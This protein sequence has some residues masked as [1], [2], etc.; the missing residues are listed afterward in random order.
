MRMPPSSRNTS[1]FR[2]SFSTMCLT[3]AAYSSGR[4]NRFGNCTCLERLANLVARLRHHRRVHDP[5]RDRAA[6]DPEARELA[7]DGEHHPE[8]AALR[9]RVGD[10][11]DLPFEARDGGGVDDHAS[12][13]GLRRLG[14]GD[15]LGGKPDHVERADEVHVH[16]STEAVEVVRPV[17]AEH[18]LGPADPGAADCAVETAERVDGGRHGAPDAVLVADVGLDEPARALALTQV[19][20]DDVSAGAGELLGRR[21]AEARGPARDEERLALDPQEPLGTA[22]L[23][24]WSRS[25]V[26]RNLPTAVLGISSTNSYRS[27]SHHFAY[28]PLRWSVSC[29]G[30]ALCPGLRTTTASGRSCHFGSGIAITAASATAGCAIS[31]FSRSTD[32][33]HSPPD[34]MTSLERSLIWMKPRGCIETM[35]PVLN[36]PSAVQRSACSGVS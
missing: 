34:L 15:R 29:S 10:L 1:P 24:N 12:F 16:D 23:A 22:A 31:A 27:G 25:A 8:H 33:I 32:E 9:R 35:S 2:Y 3:S 6:P 11:A 28:F 26:F 18:E 20:D 17:T 5:G 21:G 30:V 36:H 19:G 4:P 13:A 14:L 7:R